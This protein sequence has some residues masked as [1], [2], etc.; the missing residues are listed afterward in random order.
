MGGQLGDRSENADYTFNKR[1]L[2][3]IDRRVRFLRKFL[4]E[5]T[6]VDYSPQQE[7]K[8]FFGAWVEIE[9]EAGD[10]KKFR[11]VG[12]E[13]IYGDAKD[14]IS[15]DSPMARAMLKKQVDEEFT[16]RRRKVT[17]SGSSIRLNTTSKAQ[18]LNFLDLE[19]FGER[20]AF[21]N[22]VD[23]F[24]MRPHLRARAV[25]TGEV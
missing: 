21:A 7:G 24:F 23:L 13:E 25:F 3:Q 10:V 19:T 20:S 15:I 14:Y 5:V 6:I 11:I 12:P 17:K 18:N 16:V 4:P 9:N 2:R 8:V 22:D 1:L